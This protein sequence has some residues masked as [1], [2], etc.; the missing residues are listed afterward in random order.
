MKLHETFELKFS[1]SQDDVNTFS[2]VTGDDNPMHL[3]EEHASK[4]IFKRRILHGFLS[5]SVFSKVFG[6]MWPG[7]GTIY[8]SQN[9]NFLRPMYAGDEYVAKFEVI[10]V[11]PKNM[12]LIKT[13]ISDARGKNTIEGEALIKY[14]G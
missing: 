12:F 10:E 6:T 9:M 7:N 2:V 4:S 5:G 13:I 8:L 11:R 3:D 14:D 1:F